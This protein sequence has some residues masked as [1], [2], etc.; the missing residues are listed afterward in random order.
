MAVVG[1]RAPW[2]V[3]PGPIPR[4][5][6][7]GSTGPRFSW[8]RLS[9][10]FTAST[11]QPLQCTGGR[12]SGRPRSARM[13]LHGGPRNSRTYAG[14]AETALRRLPGSDRR[15]EATGSRL[16][17]SPRQ[18]RDRGGRSGAQSPCRGRRHWCQLRPRRQS[19][20][21]D[22]DRGMEDRVR[23][24]RRR[25]HGRSPSEASASKM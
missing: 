3:G 8:P 6:S 2:V 11:A 20:H 4:S 13:I 17:K 5:G 14:Q 12:G 25:A 16:W 7:A 19:T 24:D 21:G 18:S 23:V 15:A 9:A 10:S 22:V 1:S